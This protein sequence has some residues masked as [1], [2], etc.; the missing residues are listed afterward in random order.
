MSAK[1]L[2]AGERSSP[3]SGIRVQQKTTG[4][5][6]PDLDVPLTRRRARGQLVGRV[7]TRPSTREG[8]GTLNSLAILAS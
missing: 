5:F 2:E 4:Y 3:A 7:V 8:C 6:D 1:D